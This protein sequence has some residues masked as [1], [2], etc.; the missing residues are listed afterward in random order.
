MHW[1]SFLD[2]H[3]R[4]EIVMFD[5]FHF[6]GFKEFVIQDDQKIINKIFYSID[7]FD[8]SSIKTTIKSLKGL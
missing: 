5:S 1:W 7:K 4:K 2:L 8:I 6:E 3:L